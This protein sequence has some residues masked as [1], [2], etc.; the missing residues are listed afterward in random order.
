MRVN[1]HRCGAVL[2][3]ICDK[4]LIVQT[5]VVDFYYCNDWCKSERSIIA[6]TKPGFKKTC[7][8]C[9]STNVSTYANRYDCT[10]VTH[11]NDCDNEVL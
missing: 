10:I 1:C 8:E 5:A 7:L 9:G 11:C 3:L 4:P 2:C 6:P